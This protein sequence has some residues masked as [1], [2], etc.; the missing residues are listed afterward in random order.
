V[1]PPAIT[2][3]VI[4]AALKVNPFTVSVTVAVCERDPLVAVG[5]SGAT[6]TAFRGEREHDSDL[7]ANAIP[8]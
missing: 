2:V 8:E 1:V 6:R 3:W 5:E 4:G 7:K